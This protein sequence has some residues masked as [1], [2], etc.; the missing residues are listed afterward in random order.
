MTKQIL[1]QVNTQL[2][3]IQNH[4]K[5]S[6]NYYAT[7]QA[8]IFKSQKQQQFFLECNAITFCLFCFSLIERSAFLLQLRIVK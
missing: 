2:T 1:N 6:G 7:K 4:R 5:L 8:M 3:T